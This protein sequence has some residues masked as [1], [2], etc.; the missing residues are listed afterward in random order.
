MQELEEAHG[1]AL[2]TAGSDG[3][4]KLPSSEGGLKLYSDRAD[5]G[6]GPAAAVCRAGSHIGAAVRPADPDLVHLSALI[7]KKPKPPRI[8]HTQPHRKRERDTKPQGSP[9]GS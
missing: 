9:S 2:E 1:R 5:T 4:E 3:S 7:L 6:V 8:T